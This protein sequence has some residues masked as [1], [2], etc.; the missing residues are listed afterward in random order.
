MSKGFYRKV[1]TI[2]SLVAVL[3]IALIAQKYNKLGFLSTP[4]P[5]PTIVEVVV[6]TKNVPCHALYLNPNDPQAV[7]PDSKCTPGVIN[8]EVNQ[9]NIKETICKKGFSA[10]IRPPVSYTNKLKKEQIL[11]YGYTDTNLKDFEEDHFISLELGGSPTD[12]KNLWPESHGSPNEK[13]KVENYL[14]EQVCNGDLT[15]Q[16]AQRE[17]STNWYNIYKNITK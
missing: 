17:I 4:I 14:H 3:L 6:P 9:S 7:L 16:E 13:D 12:P 2:G 8:A 11:Q 5:A 15:L 1:V 10:S